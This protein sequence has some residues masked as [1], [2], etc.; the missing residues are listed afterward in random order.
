MLALL[1]AT[2]ITAGVLLLA[3]GGDDRPLSPDE[4]REELATAVAD[5][6]LEANPTD[7]DA[8]QDYADQFRG[9]AE[10]LEDLVPPRGVPGRAWV[11]AAGDL[12]ARGYLTYQPR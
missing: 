10:D 5:L 4:Y 9:L 1:G 3:G 6:R 2:V 11:E 8:L 7:G 12:A